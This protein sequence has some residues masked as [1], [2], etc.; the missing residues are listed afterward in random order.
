MRAADYYRQSIADRELPLSVVASDALAENVEQVQSSAG[1]LRFGSPRSRF[2]LRMVV[3]HARNHA[4]LRTRDGRP[5]WG[6]LHSLDGTDVPRLSPEWG[7][8]A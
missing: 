8:V 5:H 1:S 7:T 6:K 2:G 3:E 4:G